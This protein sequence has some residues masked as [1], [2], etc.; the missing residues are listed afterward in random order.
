MPRLE[1]RIKRTSPAD[2]GGD[3]VNAAMTAAGNHRLLMWL[4]LLL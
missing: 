2:A 1:H 3:A 4:T